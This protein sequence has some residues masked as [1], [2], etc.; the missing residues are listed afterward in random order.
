[1]NSICFYFQI[2]QPFRL[3]N[4][5]FDQIGNNDPYE[6]INLNK[7]LIDSIADSCYLPANAK[8]LDIIKRTNGKF[9]VSFSISGTAIEQF[10]LYRPDVLKSFKKLVDT[11]S[12]EILA[13][14]YYHSLSSLYSPK[15]FSRQVK[16]HTEKIKKYFNVTPTVFRNT[17]LIFSNEIAQAV[18]KMG[19][20]GILCEGVDSLLNGRSTTQV[21][22]STKLKN[23]GL[24]LKNRSLS[25]DIASRFSDKNWV[26]YPLSPSKFAGWIHSMEDN[27]QVINLFMD[28][29]TFGKQHTK[30][31]GIF[32]FLS[33]LPEEI[34]KKKGF[35]FK[36]PTQVL[37]SNTPKEVYNVSS[38]ISWDDSQRDLSAWLENKMQLEALKKVYSMEEKVMGNGNKTALN[39]WG[40][41]QASDHFYYM[42]TKKWN[43]NTYSG[44][45][46]FENPY[47]AHI[48]YMNIVSDMEE[49]L[50]PVKVLVMQHTKSA[51]KKAATSTKKTA[52][53]KKVMTPA[54]ETPAKKATAATKKTVSP[55]NKTPAKK[56]AAVT[57]KVTT[58]TALTKKAAAT[59]KVAAKT[60]PAKKTVVA[61]KKAAAVTK[62]PATKKATIKSKKET[63]S[64]KKATASAKETKAT[65]KEAKA[66]AKK[67]TVSKKNVS[68]KKRSSIEVEEKVS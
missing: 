25:D 40:K 28:Y 47:D 46:P 29:E 42:S 57:K 17:E 26:E 4:Y 10:E 37:A 67:A 35:E 44:S 52:S 14:T 68:V 5:N 12:V 19:Y 20:K 43:D 3:A 45:S 53:A 7:D 36:T 2:H 32:D 56:V 6:N 54:K 50:S 65:K 34:L 22:A 63:S 61:T 64:A 1:M 13:E 48:Y 60:V 66:P 18:A 9:K 38:P 33:H 55:T 24:L 49:A 51:T 41:L 62:K 8:I 30:E 27:S 39:N 11:G 16:M 59:K 31:T 58:K 15:E 23:F 21:F